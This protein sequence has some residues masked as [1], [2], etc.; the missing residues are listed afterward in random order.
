MHQCLRDK[1][2]NESQ[3][4]AQQSEP[5]TAQP[6]ITDNLQTLSS[7][8]QES[9]EP[10]SATSDQAQ[11]SPSHHESSAAPEAG[12]ARPTGRAHS[13]P[14]PQP[15]PHAVSIAP[16]RAPRRSRENRPLAARSRSPSLPPSRAIGQSAADS[17]HGAYVT[18]AG[19]DEPE[20]LLAQVGGRVPAEAPPR[21]KSPASGAA[22]PGIGASVCF[23]AGRG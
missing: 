1:N 17:R 3:R 15:D 22:F 10:A 20:G 14:G 12:P 18:S 23:V 5:A 9:S 6:F 11:P 8:D 19:S 21:W 7:T 16:G 4:R 13:C 2:T